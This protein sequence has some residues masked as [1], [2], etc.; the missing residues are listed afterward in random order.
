MGNGAHPADA[1]DFG[2]S[3]PAFV[4]LGRE[5]GY[6][7]VGAQRLGFNAFFM[8]N[9]VGLDMFPE[10]TAAQCFEVPAQRRA[11]WPQRRE[12]LMKYEW[13]EI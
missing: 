4:K 10:I 8:R 11:L 5:K 7:L 1:V 12:A 3:L 6:R 9:D 2:A 13:V